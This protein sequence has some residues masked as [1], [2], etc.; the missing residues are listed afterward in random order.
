MGLNVLGYLPIPT[1]LHCNVELFAYLTYDCDGPQ[2][3]RFFP[4]PP[5]SNCTTLPSCLVWSLQGSSHL[6]PVL[7]KDLSLFKKN[8][9]ASKP[10][11]L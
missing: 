7:T 11:L 10:F 2:R 1:I 3:A 9:N 5:T 8:L 6:S 4:I